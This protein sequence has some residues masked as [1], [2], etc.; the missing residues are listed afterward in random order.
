[1]VGIAHPTKLPILLTTAGYQS[2]TIFASGTISPLA[3]EDV[4]INLQQLFA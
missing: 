2:E 3:F 4:S 1:V